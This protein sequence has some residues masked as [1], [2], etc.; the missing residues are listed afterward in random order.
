[1][2]GFTSSLLSNVPTIP[3]LDE[4]IV[5]P[6]RRLHLTLGVMS[7]EEDSPEI[8][9]APSAAATSETLSTALTLLAFLCPRILAVLDGQPLHIPLKVLDIM[10]SHRSERET[11]TICL[12]VRTG[13]EENR[14]LRAVCG[15]CLILFCIGRILISNPYF[16]SGYYQISILFC[17]I[18]ISKL[19]NTSFIQ[20]RL[21]EDKHRPLK[22]HC[23][24]LNTV[25]RGHSLKYST[26]RKS[27][28][29]RLSISPTDLHSYRLALRQR[30]RERHLQ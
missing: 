11:R 30:Q 15:A 7:L 10:R 12:L 14:K 9:S 20:A 29:T 28:T 16:S 23:T 25:H 2:S 6:P 13:S 22:L 19:I 21:V 26:I 27:T 5:I 18:V 17:S 3:G 1:M 4:S 24:L 8:L